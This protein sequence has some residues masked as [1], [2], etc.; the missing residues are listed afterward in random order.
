MP[1]AWLPCPGNRSAMEGGIKLIAPHRP[2]VVS[3]FRHRTVHVSNT[4]DG[5]QRLL[6]TDGRGAGARR[7]VASRGHDADVELT[8]PRLHLRPFTPA[9]HD[10]IHAVYADPE[11]M[12][13][14]G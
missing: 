5:R 2:G 10:A 1:S 8:T 6:W 11:V 4:A 9:D 12:R 7:S 14:V 13:Y 3:A